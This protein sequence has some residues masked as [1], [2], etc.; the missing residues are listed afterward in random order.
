[1]AIAESTWFAASKVLARRSARQIVQLFAG[2]SGKTV[3]T[4][5]LHE[6]LVEVA[7]G[8]SNLT[9][10]GPIRRKLGS[11][12]RSI[13]YVGAIAGQYGSCLVGTARAGVGRRYLQIGS[14]NQR[15][16]SDGMSG[17]R[18]IHRSNGARVRVAHGSLFNGCERAVEQRGR[19]YAASRI[20]GVCALQ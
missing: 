7:L 5:E 10:D 19:Q 17:E 12:Q 8:Q 13:G 20:C 3:A 11:T 2:P 9:Q 4:P 1:M 14:I 18:R 15:Q 16:R 6:S